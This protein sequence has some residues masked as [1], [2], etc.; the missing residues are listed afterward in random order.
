MD[1]EWFVRGRST[2]QPDLSPAMEKKQILGCGYTQNKPCSRILIMSPD[3]DYHIGLPLQ[4]TT[5]K[6]IIVQVS[7]VSSRQIKL[8]N[9][10]ELVSALNHLAAI[11]QIYVIYLCDVILTAN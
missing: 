1:S 5:D 7:A 2:A 9:L 10:T 8:V 4:C 11:A 3:T 6:Q